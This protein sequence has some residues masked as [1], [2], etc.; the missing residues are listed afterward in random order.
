MI[1]QE[2]YSTLCQ[3]KIKDSLFLVSKLILQDLD[4]NMDIIQNTFIATCSYIGSYISLTEIRLLIDTINDVIAFIEDEQIV[5]KHV[6]VLVAKLCLLCDMYIKA[7]I[8]RT[9]TLN[10]RILRDKIIDMFENDSFK[11]SS[12][13]ISKF[14]GIIPPTDSPSYT[15]ATQILTGYMYILKQLESIPSSD[16]NKLSDIANKIRNSFDY[17]IR[18]R[19]TFE[20]KFYESDNDA[21]WFL[22]G[23]ISLLYSNS[24]EL[25]NVYQLFTHGYSKKLKNHRVGLLWLSGI[26]IVYISKKDSARIW[27]QGEVKAIKKVEELSL[28]LYNDIKRELMKNNEIPE[29]QVQEKNTTIDGIDYISSFRPVI[30][31]KGVE[32]PIATCNATKEIK[33]IRCKRDYMT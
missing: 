16:I 20:T 22:W 12:S 1:N 33:S 8:T 2:L 17:I 15:L 23:I 25:D 10:I 32:E 6:Y 24:S 7:P 13:G 4:K 5:I 14:E 30:R 28:V 3:A 29:Q 26:L 31:E 27:N 18:K 11:L 21:V 19:Y 9:G